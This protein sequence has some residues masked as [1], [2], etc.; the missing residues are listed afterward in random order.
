M[1]T[2]T[3]DEVRDFLGKNPGFFGV[4]FI[5]KDGTERRM[6][7]MMGVKKHLAGGAPAYDFTAKGLLPVWDPVAFKK[8]PH[9]ERD[10]GYR[11][12]TCAAIKEIRCRRKVWI[13]V[14]GQITEK[15]QHPA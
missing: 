8:K 5:K 12:I 2:L 6:V 7:C 13:V 15:P 10:R 11:S 4:T 14:D 1:N 9:G 3:P